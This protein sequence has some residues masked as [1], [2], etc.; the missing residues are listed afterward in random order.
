[1]LLQERTRCSALFENARFFTDLAKSQCSV[2]EDPYHGSDCRVYNR[3]AGGCPPLRLTQADPIVQGLDRKHVA[4]TVGI[5]ARHPCSGTASSQHLTDTG[6]L[7]LPHRAPMTV[8]RQHELM[9]CPWRSIEHVGGECLAEVLV[10]GRNARFVALPS[11]HIDKAVA[12]ACMACWGFGSTA[13]A[14]TRSQ[15]VW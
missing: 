12:K 4:Q 13:A 7:K 14:H 10:K 1:M 2:F 11:L 15:E 5:H 3:A 8:G 9:P 6:H